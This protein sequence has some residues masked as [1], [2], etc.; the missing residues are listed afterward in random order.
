[1]SVDRS[2]DFGRAGLVAALCLAAAL[3]AAMLAGPARAGTASDE[4]AAPRLAARYAP[5]VVVRDQAEPCDREG[6][7][8]RPVPVETVLDTPEIVLL[9]ADGNVV[10]EGPGAR[11]LAGRGPE[12]SLDLPGNPRR[13]GCGFE[14]DFR[15]L[16][17]GRPDVAYAHV[18]RDPAAPDRIA[19]QYW[20]FWYFDD[21]ANTHE[22]DWEFIQIVFPASSAEEALGVA[23]LEV[24]YSQHSGGERARWT[25]AKLERQGD[26][27]V[28]YAGVGSHANY[29]SS[30][31]FLGRNADQ[32]FGCD[33]TTGPSTRLTTE[34]RLLPSS[35]PDPDGSLA[36]LLFEGRWG[37]FQPPPYDAP[38][39]PRTK[40]EWSAP[41]AW[42]DS[43]RDSSFAIPAASTVGPTATGAFCSLVKVGGRIYTEV[44]STWV[45]LLMVV[46]LVAVGGV[47]VRSTRWSPPVPLPVRRRRASG[48]ILR[49]AW[50]LYRRHRRPL[51]WLGALFVPAA[52]VESAVQEFVV[53]FT[54]IGALVDV[55]GRQSLVSAAVG[56][57]VVGAGHLVAAAI[58]MTGVAGVIGTIGT[59]RSVGVRDAYRLLG[60][61]L[62]SAL[63][64]VGIAAAAAVVLA[65][66]VVGIPLAVYLVVRWAVAEQSC[67]IEGLPARAALRRSRELTRRR[68]WRTAR[69][70][71][72][73]SLLGSISGPLVGI[74]L[75]FVSDLPLG[76]INA[77]SSL[78]FV[79]TMPFVGVAMA[80]LYGDLAATEAVGPDPGSGA[81]DTVR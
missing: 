41:I 58:V 49:D 74:V 3:A 80:L 60:A 27:P 39:G 54:S 13:P 73:V 1:M 66:T 46:G 26:H 32:G 21:F 69:L 23:P 78:V 42:Q 47:S 45:L 22:G 44:T 40:E 77:V 67:A 81:G 52:I 33:D 51:L 64:V 56:L 2:H 20:L 15:R 17:G 19:L 65:V 50:T 76:A 14:E 35:P 34:A 48:Q 70:A 18:A 79:I 72:L 37:E 36:W 7:A 43:L 24:G 71:A 5:I 16:G 6:E 9:D 29:F 75:L 53:S 25:D 10:T 57:L 62:S 63:G 11:D 31:L 59:G 68:W 4:D 12:T 30:D 55:A 8:Y 28:V 38:P 61:R